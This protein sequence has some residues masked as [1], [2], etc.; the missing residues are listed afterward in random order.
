VGNLL[1]LLEITGIAPFAV[2]L[3]VIGS[4][5]TRNPEIDTVG[6]CRQFGNYCEQSPGELPRLSTIPHH[7]SQ[8]QGARDLRNRN[9]LIL[10]VEIVVVKY[11]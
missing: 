4:F 6:A 11:M 1:A 7:S 8:Q 2:W 3:C 9:Y 5:G 10:F